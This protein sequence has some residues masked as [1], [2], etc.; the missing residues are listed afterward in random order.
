MEWYDD[1][2]A[3]DFDW[4]DYLGGCSVSIYEITHEEYLNY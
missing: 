3:E 2:A 4:D 1:V